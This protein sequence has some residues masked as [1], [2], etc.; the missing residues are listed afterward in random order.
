MS[1]YLKLILLTALSCGLIA[2]SINAKEDDSD[3]T[4]EEEDEYNQNYH[5]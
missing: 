5:F 4:E 3:Q 2:T 1:K